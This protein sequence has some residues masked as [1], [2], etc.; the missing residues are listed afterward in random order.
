MI[1]ILTDVFFFLLSIFNRS[2]GVHIFVTQRPTGA[3]DLP[4]ALDLTQWKTLYLAMYL[5]LHFTTFAL[6]VT[7]CPGNSHLSPR[8][9]KKHCRR[10]SLRSRSIFLPLSNCEKGAGMID[11]DRGIES[12]QPKLVEYH[13][14]QS[15]LPIKKSNKKKETKTE[16]KKNTRSLSEGRYPQCEYKN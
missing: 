3:C 15:P 7:G 2:C 10:G 5:Y 11:D 4:C 9:Q 13:K 6:F 14:R 16:R 1:Y 12:V 8:K